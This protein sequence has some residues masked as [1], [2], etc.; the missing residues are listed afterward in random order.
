MLVSLSTFLTKIDLDCR[1]FVNKEVEL[2]AFPEA[3]I[4]EINASSFLKIENLGRTFY[5]LY[6]ELF[7]LFNYLDY[8]VKFPSFE[9]NKT[10]LQNYFKFLYFN[11]FLWKGKK[12]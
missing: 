5:S 4:L 11:P 7:Y 9:M 10:E 6:N 3:L 1:N 8:Q 2:A 12:M